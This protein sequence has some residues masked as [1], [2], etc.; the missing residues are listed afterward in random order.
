MEYNEFI[1][2]YK[3]FGKDLYGMYKSCT[4]ILP[5]STEDDLYNK[6]V[7]ERDPDNPVNGNI[8]VANAKQFDLALRRSKILHPDMDEVDVKAMVVFD[9]LQKNGQDFSFEKN[10][11]DVLWEGGPTRK[12][13]YGYPKNG[14]YDEIVGNTNYRDRHIGDMQIITLPEIKAE[15]PRGT[16]EL[17]PKVNA[18]GISKEEWNAIMLKRGLYHEAIH[19]ACGTNDERKCDVF[20]LL[21]IMKEHPKHAK[22]AFDVYN[23]ARSKIGHTVKEMHSV[24]NSDSDVQRKIKGGAMTYMMPETYEKLKEYALDPSKIPSSDKGILKLAWEITEKPDFSKE[25]IQEF[26][27]VVSQDK[28]SMQAFSECAIVQ[29]CMKQGGFKSIDEYIQ[30]DKTLSQ[31]MGKKG[32]DDLDRSSKKQ[33]T[34]SMPMQKDSYFTK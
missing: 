16:D 31:F 3:D 32:I 29:S 5:Q 23:Y 1:A 18:S 21:K 4:G 24:R 28:V 15:M 10:A 9:F 12:M 6:G 19:A 14:I 25:Q 26:H 11:D 30:S 22:L 33:E 27:N 13:F 2:K 20:A 34:N 8:V 17:S 7:N